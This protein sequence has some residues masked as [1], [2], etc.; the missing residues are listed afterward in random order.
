MKIATVFLSAM[1]LFLVGCASEI[2]INKFAG[3]RDGATVAQVKA[4]VGNNGEFR[5]KVLDG[6]SALESRRYR[7]DM[8]LIFR[9]GRLVGSRT[10]ATADFDIQKPVSA[11]EMKRR[12]VAQF[13]KAEDIQVSVR[14]ASADSGS[15]DTGDLQ[16]AGHFI[17]MLP[18]GSPVV[19]PIMYAAEVRNSL[20]S[21]KLESI[22]LGAGK[23]DV[24][25][26]LGK[27]KN[28]VASDGSIW[29]YRS[30]ETLVGWEGDRVVFVR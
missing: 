9:D 6:S 2:P 7:N 21:Q 25:K 26:T 14:N 23:G 12:I 17:A 1:A 8:E 19:V 24:L 20:W 13:K 15:L 5:V 18:F 28:I 27:P 29:V 10:Q 16:V 4:H 22:A 30:G 11:R 3:I